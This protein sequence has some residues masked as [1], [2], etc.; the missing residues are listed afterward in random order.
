MGG[1]GNELVGRISDM[2]HLGE[3]TQ[4]KPFANSNNC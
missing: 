3:M 4:A 2:T 1:G